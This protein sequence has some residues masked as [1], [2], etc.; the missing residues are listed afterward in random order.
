MKD[1]VFVSYPIKCALKNYRD[2]E[3]KVANRLFNNKIKAIYTSS[4]VSYPGI[5]DID[6]LIVVK[7]NSARLRSLWFD[8]KQNYMICHP[9]YIID[10]Y[11]MENIRWVYPDFRLNL[12]KGQAVNIN[13]PNANELKAIKIILMIDVTLRHFPSDYIELL[14]SNMIT[15]RNT[16]LRLN[17][18]NHTISTYKS[19]G[20]RKKAWDSYTKES[21]NL[22]KIWFRLSTDDQNKSLTKLLKNATSISI[23]LIQ[24]LST[25]LKKNN[26]VK[27][28]SSDKELVYDGEQNKAIFV[29]DWNK[30]SALDRMLNSKK[31]YSILPLNFVPLLLEYSKENGLLSNYIRKHLK[32]KKIT[33]QINHKEVIRKR[34]KLFNHQADLA[35]KMKHRHFTAFFDYGYKSTGGFINKGSYILRNLKNNKLFKDIMFIF[36]SMKKDDYN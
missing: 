8:K 30:E 34:I 31:Y 21:E 14:K 9:F 17:S 36:A 20:L 33:Y 26:I 5:S 6:M 27:I 28:L 25:Y 3:K 11:I 32:A 16:L 19:L 7:N 2:T 15:V 18:L 29:K 22:R 23:D 12:M 24:E 4:V 35:Y 10:G 1:F 13:Q